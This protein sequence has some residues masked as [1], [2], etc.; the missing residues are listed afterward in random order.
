MSST[1]EYPSYDEEARCLD[2]K[3]ALETYRIE[4]ARNPGALVVLDEL[5]CGKHWRVKVY[6]TKTEKEEFLRKKILRIFGRV[7]AGLHR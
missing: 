7:A 4:K 5:D 2:D 3:A 6:E 1:L